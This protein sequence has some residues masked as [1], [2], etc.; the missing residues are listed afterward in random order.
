MH[1]REKRSNSTARGVLKRKEI[2][3][4]VLEKSLLYLSSSYTEKDGITS[5]SPYTVEITWISKPIKD[6]A[7]KLTGMVSDL[8]DLL[9]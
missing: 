5:H 6:S 2:E 7:G 8:S 3:W 1:L 9:L 4:S